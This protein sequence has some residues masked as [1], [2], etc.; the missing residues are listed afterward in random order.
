[1]LGRVFDA[2]YARDWTYAPQVEA[3]CAQQGVG[4]PMEPAAAS[5]PARPGRRV[6]LWG[7]GAYTPKEKPLGVAPN[8]ANQ[9]LESVV[10]SGCI[11]MS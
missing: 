4:Y 7:A 1:M 11:Y 9:L 2:T 6:R 5:T 8:A 10:V 3:P